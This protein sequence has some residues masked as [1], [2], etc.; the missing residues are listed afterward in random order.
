MKYVFFLIFGL[1]LGI[2]GRHF[3]GVRAVESIG[4]ETI[5]VMAQAELNAVRADSLSLVNDSLKMALES[6]VIPE[7]PSPVVLTDTVA[8]LLES[9]PVVVVAYIDELEDG[10]TE[11]DSIIS[12]LEEEMNETRNL[13]WSVGAESDSW[14]AAYELEAL[15]NANLYR[16]L[17]EAMKPTPWYVSEYAFGAYG[18]VAV[19]LVGLLR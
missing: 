13:L 8:V 9:V 4:N 7:R 11:R 10:I 6:V 2:L 17:E 3:H 1:V 14:K 12:V 16:A 5:A 18:A 19:G 15:A